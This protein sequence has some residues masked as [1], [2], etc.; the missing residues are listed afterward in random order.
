ML[1]FLYERKMNP[2]RFKQTTFNV[3][4]N[5]RNEL[6][7]LKDNELSSLAVEAIRTRVETS[8]IKPIGLKEKIRHFFSSKSQLNVILGKEPNGNFFLMTL[9]KINDFQF[10]GTKIPVN[11][12]D[13]AHSKKSIDDAILKTKEGIL[14][15]LSAFNKNKKLFRL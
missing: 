6:R 3:T 14:K 5:A 11:L 7:K 15:N 8:P 4:Q 9:R 12:D 13:F 1:I 10:A 2:I